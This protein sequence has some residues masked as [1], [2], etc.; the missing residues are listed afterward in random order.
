MQVAAE[1]Y[2]FCTIDPTVSRVEVLDKRF[3]WLCSHFQPAN[4]VPS[5]LQVT[6]IA[7]L[8]KGAAEGEGLGNA[9]LSHIQA[10]DCILHV[11]RAFDDP[12]VSHVEDTIDPVRDL[13]IISQELLRKDTEWVRTHKKKAEKGAQCNKNDEKCLLT[14]SP[15]T[16]RT[17]DLICQ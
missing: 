14:C 7:G 15:Y 4:R 6:D 3:D 17:D 9:F 1:N 16:S 11:V 10:V 2:P 5:F 8:V 13:E 12:E